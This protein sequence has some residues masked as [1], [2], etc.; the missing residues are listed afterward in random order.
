CPPIPIVRIHTTGAGGQTQPLFTFT[1]SL[2]RKSAV[3][4]I[5]RRAPKSNDPAR[6]VALGFATTDQPSRAAVRSV[7]F[8]LEFV[9]RSR[10]SSFCNRTLQTLLTIGCKKVRI[11]FV[12]NRCQ[13]RFAP[14]DSIKLLGPDDSARFRVPLPAAH[15]GEPLRLGEFDIFLA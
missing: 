10:A 13:F 15:A 14:G 6:T 5:L 2:P 11:L 1:Q 7:D 9:W 12:A 3:R 4:N 8:Q